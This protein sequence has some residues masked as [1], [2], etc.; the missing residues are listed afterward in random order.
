M[1]K[2]IQETKNLLQETNNKLENIMKTCTV[3]QDNSF[4]SQV[5]AGRYIT[6]FNIC[7]KQGGSIDECIQKIEDAK[8]NWK[9]DCPNHQESIILTHKIFF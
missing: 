5:Q 8:L 4:I 1:Q 9:N 3:K 6:A 7:R 2:V